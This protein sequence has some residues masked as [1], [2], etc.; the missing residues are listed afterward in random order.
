M[1]PAHQKIGAAVTIFEIEHIIPRSAGGRTVLDNLCLACPTCN[2]FK[3]DRQLVPDPVTQHAVPVFHPQRQKWQ[4]HFA[5]SEDAAEINGQVTT[6]I[7]EYREDPLG[8]LMW[9]VT[10]WKSTGVERQTYEKEIS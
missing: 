4:E 2:R 8:E 3:A 7:V 5:W 9:V 6:F 1:R 10:A